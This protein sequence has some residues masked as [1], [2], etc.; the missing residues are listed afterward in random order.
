MS[1]AFVHQLETERS[2]IDLD[3]ILVKCLR[4]STRF[5][6]DECLDT[7]TSHKAS[8]FASCTKIQCCSSSETTIEIRGK[9][10]KLLLADEITSEMMAEFPLYMGIDLLASKLSGANYETLI[11]LKPVLI[12][13]LNN[14]LIPMNLAKELESLFFASMIEATKRRSRKRSESCQSFQFSISDVPERI[15]VLTLSNTFHGVPQF[16]KKLSKDNRVQLSFSSPLPC[17]LCPEEEK[18]HYFQDI[19]IDLST[20]CITYN[21]SAYGDIHKHRILHTYALVI[22]GESITSYIS[23]TN[24]TVNEI[25]RSVESQISCDVKVVVLMLKQIKKD[26]LQSKPIRHLCDYGKERILPWWRKV[27]IE[28]DVDLHGAVH[29]FPEEINLRSFSNPTSLEDARSDEPFDMTKRDSILGINGLMKLNDL[30]CAI[31]MFTVLT[32]LDILGLRLHSESN[33]SRKSM[34]ILYSYFEHPQIPLCILEDFKKVSLHS[35]TNEERAKMSGIEIEK[36]L[37]LRRKRKENYFFTVTKQFKLTKFCHDLSLHS[38]IKINAP[39]FDELIID[40]NSSSSI[41]FRCNPKIYENNIIHCYL[42]TVDQ[43]KRTVKSYVS[44]LLLSVEEIIKLLTQ[45]RGSRKKCPF[46]KVVVVVSKFHQ[47]NHFRDIIVR[48]ILK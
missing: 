16:C 10:L 3:T 37:A 26:F 43:D 2:E 36:F 44:I 19:N 28:D 48:G 38:E 8:S 6:I 34:S 32:K 20:E 12:S 17:P 11:T 9:L 14:S 27:L 4:S 7:N 30:M 46:V 41:T 39:P 22:S 47:A 42:L 40:L 29:F 5:K 13:Y 1:N 33:I 24:L 15:E 21:S 35:M 23:I 31:Q 45:K 18:S 25:I